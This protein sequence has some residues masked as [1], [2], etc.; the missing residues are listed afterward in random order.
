MKERTATNIGVIEHW[1]SVITYEM[2][3]KLGSD[4]ILGKDTSKKLRNTV[5]FLLVITLFLRT[6]Y[7]HDSLGYDMSTEHIQLQFEQNPDGIKCLVHRE[8]AVTKTHGGEDLI[9]KVVVKKC[10]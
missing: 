6:I 4:G 7:E 9:I 8:D 1:A 5:L 3:N 2:E 10:G